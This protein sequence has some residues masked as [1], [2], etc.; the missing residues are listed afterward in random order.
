MSN[1]GM[2]AQ[3]GIKRNHDVFISYSTKNK[4]VADAIVSDFEQHGIKCWYAPRDILPGEEWVSAIKEGLHAAKILVLIYTKES[5]DSRQVMNEVALAFNAGMTIIPFRLT[6]G[7]MND[8]LEY[9]LTRVHWLD[10]ISKPL[11]QNIAQLR[12]YVSVI[13][14]RAPVETVAQKAP[15]TPPAAP[16]KKKKWVLPVIIAA[17]APVAIIG[18]IV[19]V[20]FCVATCNAVT[21]PSSTT[22]VTT[23]SSEEALN[24]QET[25]ESTVLVSEEHTGK[26]GVLRNDCAGFTFSQE[27]FED[28]SSEYYLSS[29]VKRDQISSITILS[30][31]PQEDVNGLD[32]SEAQDGSVLAWFDENGGGLYDVIIASDGKVCAPKDSTLLFGCMSNLRSLDFND[33]IDT[34]NV[35]KMDMMFAGDSM[36]NKL[37]LQCFDTSNANSMY[38]MFGYNSALNELDVRDFDTS[39]VTSF[40]CMF[41]Y[42]SSLVELDVRGFNT[43][44]AT[45]F[46]NMFGNCNSLE[47]LDVSGFN[48]SQATSF[49]QTFNNCHSLKKLDVSGFNTSQVTDFYSMF[50]SCSSLEMLDV[51]KFDTSKGTDFGGMFYKCSSLKSLDVS[52]FNTSQASNMDSMF[53]LCTGLTEP[54]NVSSF[55]TSKVKSMKQM[56]YGYP[57]DGLDLRSF[58]FTA[59]E[60]VEKMFYGMDGKT[61]YISSGADPNDILGS[62]DNVNIEVV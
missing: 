16:K 41:Y 33:S 22:S 25:S 10:A 56:F 49:Y 45:N 37:L 21:N 12:D 30:E 40:N 32:V 6:D 34:S 59:V 43:S 58:D 35:E 53:C 29:S 27:K 23:E 62:I 52:H 15:A 55:N 36:L 9:Y 38:L 50:S 57:L 4:N 51:S 1:E 39:N 3:G 18:M 14:N 2:M 47:E 19:V 46:D 31:I 42:C 61:V 20:V 7:E 60:N 13:L 24:I 28:I 44:Q 5:N 17:V 8:E 11:N 48:T 54:I 26:G